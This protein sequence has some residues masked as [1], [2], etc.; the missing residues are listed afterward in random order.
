MARRTGDNLHEKSQRQRQECPSARDDRPP[1]KC[2]PGYAYIPVPYMYSVRL[3]RRSHV[4]YAW[5]RACVVLVSHVISLAR[6]L[7]NVRAL[8]LEQ[9]S[10]FL[11][12]FHAASW[13]TGTFPE[14]ISA[15]LFVSPVGRGQAL[16]TLTRDAIGTS[17]NFLRLFSIAKQRA[18]ARKGLQHSEFP[19]CHCK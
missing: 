16:V 1:S 19:H 7:F 3:A 12:S 13:Q 14:H 11:P 5:I 10:R 4:F 8:G 9:I 6:S 17:N 18:T 2:W 15:Y